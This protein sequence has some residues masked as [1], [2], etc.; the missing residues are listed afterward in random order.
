MIKN[1]NQPTSQ[2]FEIDSASKIWSSFMESYLFCF[3]TKGND[4]FKYYMRRK[5]VE[6]AEGSRKVWESVNN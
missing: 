2:R 6:M 5:N 1:E 4:I 3:M